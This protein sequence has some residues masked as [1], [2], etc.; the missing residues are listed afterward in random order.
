M[1]ATCRSLAVLYDGETSPV[2]REVLMF[3]MVCTNGQLMVEKI[4]WRKSHLLFGDI[5]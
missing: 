4:E 5:Y 3:G 2:Q 1:A